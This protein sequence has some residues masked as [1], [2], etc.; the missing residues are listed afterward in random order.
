MVSAMCKEVERT[1]ICADLAVIVQIHDVHEFYC[2]SADIYTDWKRDID[3]LRG[4]KN[5]D[6]SKN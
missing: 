3:M 2:V 4:G 5:R 6:I 1:R